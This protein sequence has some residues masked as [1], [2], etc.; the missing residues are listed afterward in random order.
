MI[1]HYEPFPALA[2][3]SVRE[4]VSR[5][6]IKMPWPMIEIGGGI[7]MAAATTSRARRRRPR[8]GGRGGEGR[9]QWQPVP[10]TDL[11]NAAS[12]VAWLS[13]DTRRLLGSLAA[14]WERPTGDALRALMPRGLSV[15]NQDTFIIN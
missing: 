9:R 5:S 14:A 11:M 12:F 10:G 7:G 2:C 6:A 4:K 1:R 15:T 13:A 8:T 3:D